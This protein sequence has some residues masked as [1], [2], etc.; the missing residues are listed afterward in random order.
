MIKSHICSPGQTELEGILY[1]RRGINKILEDG[2]Q[3][4]EW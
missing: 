2:E 4:D 1:D 3:M